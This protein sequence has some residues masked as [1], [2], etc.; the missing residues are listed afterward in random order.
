MNETKIKMKNTIE[1]CYYYC[2]LDTNAYY[3]GYRLCYCFFII[4]PDAMYSER[5]MGLPAEN[6][7]GYDVS[8]YST[9]TFKFLNV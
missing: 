8:T 5:Y 3:I 6:K 2:T 7:E 1:T 9:I 4:F